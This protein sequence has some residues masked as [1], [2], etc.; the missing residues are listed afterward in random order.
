[1]NLY[2]IYIIIGTRKA[3]LQGVCG[4]FK[5]KTREPKGINVVTKGVNL[6]NGGCKTS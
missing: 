5:G 1:M 6:S 3:H 2:I 4:L